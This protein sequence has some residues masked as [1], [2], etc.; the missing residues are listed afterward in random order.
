MIKVNINLTIKKLTFSTIGC[1]EFNSRLEETCTNKC[2]VVFVLVALNVLLHTSIHNQEL[3]ANLIDI[4]REHETL[5]ALYL[6][7]CELT[8]LNLV[9]CFTCMMPLL[10]LWDSSESS[11]PRDTETSSHRLSAPVGG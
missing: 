8:A 7:G 10:Y 6:N 9:R 2:N 4:H 5:G 1:V 11:I 3:L